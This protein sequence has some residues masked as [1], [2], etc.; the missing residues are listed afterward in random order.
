MAAT[1]AAKV[2]FWPS[3]LADMFVAKGMDSAAVGSLS[4]SSFFDFRSLNH[5]EAFWPT[6]FQRVA[7]LKSSA[8]SST[9]TPEEPMYL[10][11]PPASPPAV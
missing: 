9:K 3:A 11:Q 7:S 5:M 8:G 10:Y 6:D 2:F 4:K 1:A